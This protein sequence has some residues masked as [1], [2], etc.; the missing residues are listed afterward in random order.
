MVDYLFIGDDFTGASDTLA[1]LAER[2][3]RARL[4]LD[5]PDPVFVAAERLDAIGLGTD[6]RAQPPH[7][8]RSRLAG[9]APR[10]LAL[11]PRFVHYKICSTFD[12]APHVG[13]VGA[14]VTALEAALRPAATLILGG[15]PSLGR[16]CVGGSLFA[17]APDGD[18]HR[19]DRHPIMSRHP[20]TPMAEADLRR[21]LAAQGLDDLALASRFA[22][23]GL[24]DSIAT[25]LA[26]GRARILVDALDQAD[27]V[28]FGAAAASVEGLVLLVGASGVAEAFAGPMA[29]ARA[30]DRSPAGPRLAVA[31][32][33]SA[34]TAR[35]VAAA[36][37]YETT[38]LAADDLGAGAA[39][40]ARR[41]A[42]RLDAGANT[43]IALDPALDYGLDPAALSQRVAILTADILALSP[44]RAVAVAGGDTS[45]A[46]VTALGARS[47]SFERRAG[48]G[49]AICRLDAPGATI[50]G[51]HLLLKG[52]Q[53][54]PEDLFDA[55]A[56]R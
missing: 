6:L 23:C 56:A 39:G 54:G 10:L 1:T 2:R 41:Q 15:Q 44:T 38:F 48:D 35:Q 28:A 53:V 22:P 33:R 30:D 50:D 4:F 17:R 19:I 37:R 8:I 3:R 16:H 7:A 24:S 11:S 42:A 34:H 21:H 9:L 40:F 43:L 45:S 25:S 18:V 46:V 31:G 20:V 55:F 49:V 32:S 47:L 13:S 5:A 29:E 36:R 51:A 52:G 14:A 27:V 26:Q 12:S